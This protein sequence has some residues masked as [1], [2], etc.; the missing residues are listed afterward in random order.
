MAFRRSGDARR[1]LAAYVPSQALA[2]GTRAA[3]ATLGYGVVPATSMGRFEDPD[4]AADLRVADIRLLGRLPDDDVPVI[5]LGSGREP[6]PRDP[7]VVGCVPRPAEVATL[8]PLLQ[9]ALERRPRSAAR[10]PARIQA[11]CTVADRRWSGEVVRLSQTGC[12]VL[13]AS[14]LRPGVE[15]NL[16]F[17]LPAGRMVSTRARISIHTPEGTGIVFSDLSEPSF[18]AIGDYV[19][20]KLAICSI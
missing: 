2:P 4:R 11:R 15:L 7:R 8:Y 3:L 1:T 5:L 13:G 17:P 12:L 20:R 19:Q 6:T 14:D 9:S 18:R 16:S 10:A